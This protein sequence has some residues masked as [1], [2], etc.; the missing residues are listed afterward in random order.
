MRRQLEPEVVG[1]RIERAEVL[2]ER[3]TRPE[4]PAIDRGGARR[5]DRRGGRAARQVPDRAP[6]RRLGPGHAPADDR[7]PAAAPA[8]CRRGRR[9]DAERAASAARGSMS[10]TPRRATCARGSRFD[11]G[12]E[13][14]FTDAR[15]FGHGVVLAGGEIDDYFAARLGVEPLSGELTAEGLLRAGGGPAGAAEVVSAQPDPDRRDRQH[16]RR[17]GAVSRPAASALA[18]GLD[19]ARA[20]R[21][22]A[23]R[24]SSRRS[25]WRCEKRGSSIDDYRDARGERGSMQDEFLVHTREGEPCLRCGEE[26]RR[27]VVSGRSTYFCPG[28]QRRLRAR[29]RR[30]RRL[31]API[32]PPARLR[33][34]PL[35]RRRGGHRLH[36]GD[37][38]AGQQRRGRRA[39][40][41]PG[42]AR[43]RRDRPAGGGGGGERGDAQRRQ[44]L[45]ARGRRRRDALARGA[46]PRLRDAG[47]AGADRAGGDDLRPRRG[48][49]GRSSGCRRGLRGLRGRGR[50]GARARPGRRRHRRRGGQDP[51]PRARDAGGGRLRGGALRARRDRRRDRG[52]QRVRRR[53]RRRRPDPGRRRRPRRASRSRPPRRSPR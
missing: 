19:E 38:A 10:R 8:R 2:D 49:P 34:R 51:R 16:L 53:D 39:R 28:C 40:R 35:D 1:R 44:R 41:R 12:S 25:S 21:G 52:R 6:R 48:R 33:D 36:G 32:A 42:H 22:A 4:P 30:R 31:S 29:P 43:D 45:R 26:I 17:R 47:R 3:W 11:D 5:P 15:R 18:G 46:R 24:G 7:Q 23:S 13:L 37:R 9:P 14:W 27:I 50:R 20:L